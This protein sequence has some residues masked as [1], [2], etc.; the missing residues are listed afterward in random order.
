MLKSNYHTHTV[1]CGHAVGTIQENISKAIEYGYETL[2]FSEHAP[3]PL[4]E[5]NEV[6][7]KRLFANENMTMQELQANYLDVLSKLKGHCSLDIKI[8][9]ESEYVSGN[10]EFYKELRSKVEYMILGVH[11]F[12]SDSKLIDTYAQID[13]TTMYDYARNIEEAL[14]TGLFDYL[15]HPD[16]YLYENL[17]FD[18]DARRVADMICDSCIKYNIPMEINCNGKGRY[19]RPDFYEY[20]K[21]KPVKFIIGVD[22]H[23]PE[24]LSGEHI[25][26]SIDLAKRLNLKLV[27]RI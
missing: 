20:I 27:E 10:L 14:A 12:K 3:L 9:L 22:S 15:A 11:F 16:L 6:D 26:N 24:R 18:E 13:N 23:D 25:K 19:P 1:L 2:G 21:N 4:H 8:G 5:F 17:E 7:A